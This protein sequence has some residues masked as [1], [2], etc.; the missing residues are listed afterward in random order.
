MSEPPLITF[1]NCTF[2]Y[3]G[4]Y[5]A[6]VVPGA[7]TF[8]SVGAR[9]WGRRRGISG[10]IDHVLYKLWVALSKRFQEHQCQTGWTSNHKAGPF[11]SG[12]DH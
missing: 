2:E 1:S 9:P 8:S 5:T 3:P 10:V 6:V 7:I 12:V 4:P 11:N